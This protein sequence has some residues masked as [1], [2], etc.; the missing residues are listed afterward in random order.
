M[1]GAEYGVERRSGEGKGGDGSRQKTPPRCPACLLIYITSAS[2]PVAHIAQR[3]KNCETSQNCCM[4]LCTVAARRRCCERESERERLFADKVSPSVSLFLFLSLS[5]SLISL[6]GS[7]LG[8]HLGPAVVTNEVPYQKTLEK[9]CPR[10]C[11]TSLS[12]QQ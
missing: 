11:H 12:P 3:Q 8:F 10:M 9:Y 1:I 6:S 2:R 5:L 4:R 7:N